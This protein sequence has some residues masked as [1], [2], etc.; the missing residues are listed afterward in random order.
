MVETEEFLQPAL[1]HTRTHCR[2]RSLTHTH[3]LMLVCAH[4]A[5]TLVLSTPTSTSPLPPYYA[6]QSTHTHT[7]R[8]IQSHTRIFVI[9][10]FSF[11][12]LAWRFLIAMISFHL[13]FNFI[14]FQTRARTLSLHLACADCSLNAIGLAYTAPTTTQRHTQIE[15]VACNQ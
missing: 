7:H 10:I 14:S 8:H 12:L 15:Q 4:R 6:Q 11:R 3:T 9:F 2:C 1:T 13:C 5:R